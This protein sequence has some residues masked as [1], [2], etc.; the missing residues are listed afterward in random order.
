MLFENKRQNRVLQNPNT[1]I[2]W[3]VS[4]VKSF[5]FRVIKLQTILKLHTS[6]IHP[7][8]SSG[9]LKNSFKIVHYASIKITISIDTNNKN[10]VQSFIT[11]I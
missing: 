3:Y 10:R 5:I 2:F 8:I 11:T 6:T 7:N 1:M 4:I 9:I